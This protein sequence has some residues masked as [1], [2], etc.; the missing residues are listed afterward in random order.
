LAV[1]SE[2]I[3]FRTLSEGDNVLAATIRSFVYV[4]SAYEYLLETPEGEIR[5]DAPDE[6]R[7][8]HIGLYLPPDAM[9]VLAEDSP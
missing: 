3:A 9:V 6:L 1:R 8:P 7:G 5:A 4:G 2:R